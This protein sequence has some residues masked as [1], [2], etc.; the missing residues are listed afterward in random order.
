MR[1]RLAGALLVASLLTAP[2]TALACPVCFDANEQN[3]EAFI[4]TTVLLSSLP[5]LMVGGAAWWIRQLA[6]ES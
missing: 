4:L 1:A 5:L 3:R 6:R 2:A